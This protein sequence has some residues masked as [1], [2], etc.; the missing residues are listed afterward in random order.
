ML[1]RGVK[2]ERTLILTDCYAE[3][4]ERCGLLVV[5]SREKWVVGLWV[6]GSRDHVGVV[7]CGLWVLAVGS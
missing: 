4:Q 1:N 5:G 2:F 6:V 7:D 3:K